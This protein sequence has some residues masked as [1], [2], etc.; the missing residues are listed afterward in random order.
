MNFLNLFEAHDKALWISKNYLIN[1]NS[2]IQNVCIISC[3]YTCMYLA[4]P[5]T[6]ITEMFN[7]I[8]VAHRIDDPQLGRTLEV[9]GGH[10]GVIGYSLNDLLDS[11]DD[12]SLSLWRRVRE[13]KYMLPL[14]NDTFSIYRVAQ[15]NG[16][17]DFLELCSDQ[18][19][20]FFSLLDRAS[21]P[22]YNNTKIIKFG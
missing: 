17:V 5:E 10:V 16:T 3:I 13:L 6:S 14:N 21:F 9:G 7:C 18:Q 15:K 11:L 1:G 12:I 2:L 4:K 19:L 22:H 20:Y 8:F